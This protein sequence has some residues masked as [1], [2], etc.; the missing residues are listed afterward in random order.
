MNLFF[1]IFYALCGAAVGSFLNVCI[2]RIPEHE[3]VITGRS[4]CPCCKRPLPAHTMV[5]ILS[6][7]VLRGKCR[8]CGAPISPQYPAVEALTAFSFALCYAAKGP[9]TRSLILCAFACLLIVAAGIDAR[10]MYIPDGIPL[11]ILLLGILLAA[12]EPDLG[13]TERLIGILACGG[14]LELLRLLTKGGVGGGDVKLLAAG[15]F[16]IGWKAGIL[17]IFMAYV[18][19]GLWFI[20][21]LLKGRINGKTRVP[22]APFFG[23]SLMVCGL[24]SKEL[25][26]WYLG[27]FLP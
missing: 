2:L 24:Y 16:L 1:F 26:N 21:P 8:F 3:T 22:M 7:F 23:L 12:L 15:G 20:I 4:R 6:W 18:I 11:C 14:F 27:L 17:A 5:P 25:I 13:I 9:G 10:Y 19:A